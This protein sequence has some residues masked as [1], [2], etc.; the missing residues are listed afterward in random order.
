MV[1]IVVDNKQL[2]IL[3][4]KQNNRNLD[5]ADSQFLPLQSVRIAELASAT[6]K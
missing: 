3:N 2:I 5:R 1:I 4:K 6:S